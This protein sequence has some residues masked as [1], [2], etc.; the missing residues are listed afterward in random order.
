MNFIK[1]RAVKAHARKLEA[2]ESEFFKILSQVDIRLNPMHGERD[3]NLTEDHITTL[4]KLHGSGD[5]IIELISTLST[6][7]MAVEAGSDKMFNITLK[8]IANQLWRVEDDIDMFRS[9]VSYWC[10]KI[11]EELQACRNRD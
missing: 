4:T 10:N 7:C 1:R 8:N 3:P 9:T 6:D 5:K 11:D 2:K